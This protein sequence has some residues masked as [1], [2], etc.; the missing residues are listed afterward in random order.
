[1]RIGASPARRVLVSGFDQHSKPSQ[2]S[3][4]GA[5]WI[6]TREQLESF[7]AFLATGMNGEA[8]TKDHGAPLRLVVPRWYGC[9]CIKWLN[10]I[11][12]VGEDAP[13]TSQM[14]EFASRTHQDGVP[15][16]ARDYL[17]ASMDQAAMP[18]RVERWRVASGVLYR[19][20]GVMWGGYA[21]TDALELRDNPDRPREPGS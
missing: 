5:S 8:L 12:L 17:A 13:A 14:K 20:V 10:E 4:P 6:F 3:T 7:G 1:D 11:A 19:I 2:K 21:L 16:L 9:T 18:V 15:A